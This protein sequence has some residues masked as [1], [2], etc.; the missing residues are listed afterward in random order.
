MEMNSEQSRLINLKQPDPLTVLLQHPQ[1]Q[2]EQQLE[3]IQ[4]LQKEF[5]AIILG[6]GFLNLAS[7]WVQ[8]KMW[9]L[10]LQGSQIAV[11]LV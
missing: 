4:I 9:A 8:E 6:E 5:K 7:V 2:K 3:P 1:M 10:D 11:L